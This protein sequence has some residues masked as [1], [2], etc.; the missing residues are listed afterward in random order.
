MIFKNSKFY[1]FCK[2]LALVC[3]DAV[4]IAYNELS[5]VWGLPYGEQVF[6]TCCIVSVLL[7]T[8]I[9]V[10]GIRYK[11]IPENIE[12]HSEPVEEDI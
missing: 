1:D 12:M 9:G 7:G 3:L 6:K 5:E 11:N 4:G 2:W 10:S 8:L